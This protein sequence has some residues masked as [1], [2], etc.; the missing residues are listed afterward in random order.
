[1]SALVLALALA[2]AASAYHREEHYSTVLA[3]R[4][5][6][7]IAVC[8]QLPDEAEEL[9]AVQLYRRLM[10]HPSDFLRWALHEEGPADRVGRVVTIQQLLHGLTGGS[11][12]GVRTVAEAT[13]RDI[14]AYVKSSKPDVRPDALC[15]LGFA[16]H[17]YGDSFSHRRLRRP[18]A[19]YPTGLGHFLDGTRPDLPLFSPAR[20]EL[21]KT[22]VS[23]LGAPDDG[24][25]LEPLQE[26]AFERNGFNQRALKDELARRLEKRGLPGRPYRFDG[27]ARKRGCQALVQQVAKDAGIGRPPSCEHA[28]RIYSAWAE[29]EFDAYDARPG[30]GGPSRAFTFPYFQGSPF[31]PGVLW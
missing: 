21:W 19:M 23:S 6:A 29:K 13:I 10:N 7:T 11:S 27:E 26:S 18:E 9:S 2:P 24:K 4:G 12:E 31:E 30:E 25:G 17:L 28:W 8:A 5:D 15:A 1:L 3:A 14:Q 20:L 16:L 22:Y